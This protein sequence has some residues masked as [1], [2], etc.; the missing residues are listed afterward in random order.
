M[1]TFWALLMM[2]LDALQIFMALVG[3]CIL[4][5]SVIPVI[6]AVQADSTKSLRVRAIILFTLS[7]AFFLGSA[8]IPSTE[9]V[10]A[11]YPTLR[12]KTGLASNSIE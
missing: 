2:R 12:P 10:F 11:A 8:L 1:S 9:Q 3:S 4:I 7:T 6:E 5:I